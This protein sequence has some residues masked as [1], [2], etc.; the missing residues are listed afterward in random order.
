MLDFYEGKA[1]KPLKLCFCNELLK[2]DGTDTLHFES[3]LLIVVDK[4]KAIIILNWDIMGYY[5]IFNHFSR[6]KILDGL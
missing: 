3:I 4:N 5:G 2:F 6:K 1:I